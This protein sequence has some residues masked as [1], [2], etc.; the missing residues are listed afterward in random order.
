MLTSPQVSNTAAEKFAG[1]NYLRLHSPRTVEGSHRMNRSPARC[2]LIR[3]QIKKNSIGLV[4]PIKDLRRHPSPHYHLFYK[5]LI[6][7]EENTQS[8]SLG[9]PANLLTELTTAIR[10]DVYLPGDPK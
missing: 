7:P 10:G 8:L 2:G 5:V 4:L 3:L 1:N 9:L 6:M